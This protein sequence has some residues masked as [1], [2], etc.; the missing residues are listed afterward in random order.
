MMG[1]DMS[2]V[3][4][5]NCRIIYAY[6][7]NEHTLP[8]NSVYPRALQYAVKENGKGHITQGHSKCCYM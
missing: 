7:L 1:I 5:G 8:S 3:I 6:A 4:W 2:Q